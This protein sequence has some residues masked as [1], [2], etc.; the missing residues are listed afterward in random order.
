[1]AY[2]CNRS[3]SHGSCDVDDG[4]VLTFV[5]RMGLYAC[6]EKALLLTAR[7]GSFCS[8]FK[9]GFCSAQVPAE[10]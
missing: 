6:G 1:M 5:L 4:D 7:L 8:C 2:L 10:L 3:S 9:Y